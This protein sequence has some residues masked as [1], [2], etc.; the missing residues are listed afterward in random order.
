ME[1]TEGVDSVDELCGHIIA[2][3]AVTVD[4]DL[5]RCLVDT[6]TTHGLL[7]L[8][9]RAVGV[10]EQFLDTDRTTLVVTG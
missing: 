9:D 1:T 7:H 3:T 2:G 4:L 10:E 8:L 6:H 5:L